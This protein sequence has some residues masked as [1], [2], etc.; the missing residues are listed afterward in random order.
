[1]EVRGQFHDTAAL[2]TGKAARNSLNKRLVMPQT[3]SGRFGA[4][5]PLLVLAKFETQIVQLVAGS[6]QR[7]LYIK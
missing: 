3:G 4:K 6:L 2:I 5:K 7:R 1:M